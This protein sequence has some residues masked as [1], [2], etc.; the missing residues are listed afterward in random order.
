MDIA[1]ELERIATRLQAEQAEIEQAALEQG[2]D[3]LPLPPEGEEDPQLPE[4]PAAIELEVPPTPEEHG[5]DQMAEDQDGDERELGD[6][7]VRML[8]G[9]EKPA[10]LGGDPE[11][12]PD[13]DP[14][15]SKPA[16][17]R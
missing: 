7:E 5:T 17:F 13:Y 8:F 1:G 10:A 11:E 6:D 4:D 14:L 12:D 16:A 2:D 3:S 9:E 15:T